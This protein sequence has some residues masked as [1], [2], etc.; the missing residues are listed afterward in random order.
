MLG[1]TKLE[2][3][4]SLECRWL[5]EVLKKAQKVFRGPGLVLL[6]HDPE[7]ES[8]HAGHTDISTF[9]WKLARHKFY[10]NK[11]A[12]EHKGRQDAVRSKGLKLLTDSKSAGTGRVV[13]AG[14]LPLG[15]LYVTYDCGQRG[16]NI[17][18]KLRPLSHLLGTISND[19][20]TFSDDIKHV[21]G[22]EHLFWAWF[23]G[24]WSVTLFCSDF[25]G[26]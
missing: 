15:S 22:H 18:G 17:S 20:W 4:L 25:L 23:Q 2:E 9:L 24:L 21:F 16:K 8:Y 26:Y 10:I 6:F 11:P 7:A 19:D 13:V 1:C 3:F 5:Y 12:R 14:S